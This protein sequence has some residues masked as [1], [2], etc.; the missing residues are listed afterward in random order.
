MSETRKDNVV[1]SGDLKPDP[2]IKEDYTKTIKISDIVPTGR[3]VTEN[4]V[5]KV[6]EQKKKG[7]KDQKNKEKKDTKK[8]VDDKDKE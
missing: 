5:K 7:I 3:P 1:K 4:D 8:K 2:K 6:I